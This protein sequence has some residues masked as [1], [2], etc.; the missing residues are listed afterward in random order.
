[1]Q[2]STKFESVN[3]A[4]SQLGADRLDN[5]YADQ[6]NDAKQAIARWQ[7]HHAQPVQPQEAPADDFDEVF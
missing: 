2:A 4:C 1:M 6:V 5:L 7:A 3:F